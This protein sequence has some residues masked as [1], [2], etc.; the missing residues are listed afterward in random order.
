MN[1]KYQIQH[2]QSGFTLIEMMIAVGILAIVS[3][4][5]MSV[6]TDYTMG[7]NVNRAITEIRMIDLLIKDY[8]LGHKA[9]PPDLAA[10]GIDYQ[11]P[12][13]NDYQYYD[14]ATAKGNGQLRKDK[15][16]VPINTDF[17]LYSMGPD[18]ESV[19]PLTAEPSRDDIVRANNGRY[20]GVAEGY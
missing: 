20:V 11:D 13:G 6:Y 2:R 7:A 17:D 18:G 16:L 10:I 1:K 9:N 12:W 8:R 19:S 5:S 4:L 3:S 15:N 14:I